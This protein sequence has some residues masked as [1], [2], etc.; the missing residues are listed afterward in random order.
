[1]EALRRAIERLPEAQREVLAL[2]LGDELSYAEI[3]AI[4]AVPIGTVRSR[5]HHAVRRLRTLAVD[6][7]PGT[8][9][10]ASRRP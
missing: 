8:I 6:E 1:M 10:D 7:A 4:L 5:I 3:A 2:R 9:V